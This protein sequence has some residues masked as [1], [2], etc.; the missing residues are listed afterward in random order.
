MRIRSASAAVILA[1]ALVAGATACSEGSPDSS[2]SSASVA[3]SDV[4]KS[5]EYQAERTTALAQFPTHPAQ[6][7]VAASVPLAEVLWMLGVPL[8]GVPSTTTQQLPAALDSV[9]RIGSTMS[10][11]VEKII[12][13]APDLVVAADGAR[14]MVDP[15]LKSAAKPAAYLD[16]DSIDDLRFAVDVLATAFDKKDAGDK[17]LAGIDAHIAAL[18]EASEGKPQP[19]VLTLIGASDSFMVMSGDSFIG[20]LVAKAGADNIA[21]SALHTTETYT[22]VNLEN[23]IA[24]SPDVVL[25]LQS[26]DTAKAQAA[27]DAEVAKNPAWQ[28]LPAYKNKRIHVV[29][30]SAFG[31]T[32]VSGLDK[33]VP[34]L[35]GLLYP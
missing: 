27:F 2:S 32:S 6:K 19:K 21:T 33:A 34:T 24:A 3:P 11:D 20:S 17:V 22:A 10:L 1:V 28:S 5:P 18:T 15:A 9:P 13:I 26:G 16:T 25:V 4:A 30:Y 23:I 35:S 31:Y 7:V 29:D 12:S 8:S 14:S